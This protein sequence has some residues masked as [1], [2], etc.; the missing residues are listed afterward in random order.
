[1][2]VRYWRGDFPVGRFD[3]HSLQKKE[4]PNR[5]VCVLKILS[6]V[7][8][9]LNILNRVWAHYWQFLESSEQ[10]LNIL[11]IMNR[12]WTLLKILK[13]SEQSENSEH[14]LNRVW[15]LL[16]ILKIVWT[17]SEQ[18]LNNVWK[19]WTLIFFVT[20]QHRYN[21]WQINRSVLKAL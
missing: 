10:S 19:V 16:N 4:I 15:T 7:W 13:K 6:R 11:K 12:V 2:C 20:I 9:L 14:I 17:L 18:S 21:L 3:L 1:M 8:T 5:P